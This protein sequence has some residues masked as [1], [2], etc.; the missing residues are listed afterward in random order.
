MDET[1]N[2]RFKRLATYRTNAVLEK[3]RILG[4]LSNKV[5]YDYSEEEISKIFLAIDSQLRTIK[6]KFSGSTIKE[7][8]L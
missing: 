5:N 2:A 8:K 1:R 4:N 7:F 3:L 6:A